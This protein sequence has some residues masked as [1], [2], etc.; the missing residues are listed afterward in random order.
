MNVKLEFYEQIFATAEISQGKLRHWGNKKKLDA[1]S[2]EAFNECV[3]CIRKF[4]F[5]LVPRGP[6]ELVGDG[7]WTIHA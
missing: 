7:N 2:S 6:Y 4:S 5:G 1:I 3:G